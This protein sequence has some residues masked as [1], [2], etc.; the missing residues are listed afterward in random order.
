[1]DFAAVIGDGG[2]PLRMGAGPSMIPR[3]NTAFD[4]Q[5][6]FKSAFTKYGV[7]TL[8]ICNNAIK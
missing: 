7:T 3:K 6:R 1:M 5:T 8:I 2:H 4:G